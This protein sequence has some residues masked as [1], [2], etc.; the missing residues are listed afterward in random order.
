M[1]SS[2]GL[3]LAAA[4]AALLVAGPV[5]AGKKKKSASPPPAAAQS[6]LATGQCDG[7]GP[8]E[9]GAGPGGSF[10][11]G[12]SFLLE[13]FDEIDTSKDGLLSK[14]EIEAWVAQVR[15]QMQARQQERFAAAD[16]D[17]D[18]ALSREEARVGAPHLFD[19]FDFLDADGNGLL[20]LAELEQLRDRELLRQR[21]LE[22]IRL[23]D[24][25]SN[26]KLD[27]AEVQVAFP[28]L[29]T[30]FAQMDRDGDGYL[31]VEELQ[32]NRRG[33]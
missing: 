13:R 33:F 25:D 24:T 31:S 32:R 7:S 8:A 18:G 11:A 4:V 22:R 16:T 9:K 21:V 3:I 10:G 17:G 2:T 30:R 23:A 26:G 5:E 15:E 1:K 28:Q 20:T 14:E 29:A 19:H 6:G 27:L 12:G